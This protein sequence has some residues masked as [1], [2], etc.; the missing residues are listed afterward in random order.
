MVYSN[1]IKLAKIK[2]TAFLPFGGKLIEI[3][4]PVFKSLRIEESKRNFSINV[5]NL[6]EELKEVESVTGH[7]K[8]NAVVEEIKKH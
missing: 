6:F 8:Y 2:P 7:P 4:F 1:L 5:K 3:L